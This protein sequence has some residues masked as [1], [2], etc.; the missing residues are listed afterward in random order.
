MFGLPPTHPFGP[1][2]WLFWG[3]I[4]LIPGALAVMVMAVPIA[5]ATGRFWL[6]DLL[7]SVFRR[8]CHQIPGRSFWLLGYPFSF[9]FSCRR[10]TH[11][12][13]WVSQARRRPSWQTR[14]RATGRSPARTRQS[15]EGGYHA[16]G[17]DCNGIAP[18]P[19]SR[20]R[21]SYGPSWLRTAYPTVPGNSASSASRIVTVVASTMYPSV[22]P[23]S[24]PDKSLCCARA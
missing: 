15:L 11:R 1:V 8:F 13:P 5:F 10:I 17:P 3:P 9:Q 2:L 20:R 21:A 19:R 22:T 16:P 14:G 12:T 7:Y 6:G 4:L 23:Q 18:A 24:G